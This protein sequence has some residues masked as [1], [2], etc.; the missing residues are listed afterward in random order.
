[1]QSAT[2]KLKKIAVCTGA[3]LLAF[4]LLFETLG[5][6]YAYMLEPLTAILFG[7][8]GAYVAAEILWGIIYAASFI[9]PAILFLLMTKND[10]GGL[11]VKP[12][13]PIKHIVPIIFA[14]VAL[15]Y[16]CGFVNAM[17]LPT[18]IA[19]VEIPNPKNLLEFL[20]LV[21]T[22]A[23]VPAVSEE[24]LFRKTILKAL[25]PYGEGFAIITSA[26]LFGLMHQNIR[27][28]FYATMAGILLG[29]VYSRTRSYL[30]VFLIHLT[31]NFITTIESAAM[32]MLDEPYPIIISSVLISAMLISGIVSIIFLVSKETKKKDIYTDGSFEKTY[33]PSPNYVS[34]E[35]DANP[36]KVFFTSP[37]VLIFTIIS[38]VISIVTIII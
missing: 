14:C 30:C 33:L 8:T 20:L 23:V 38:I 21:F 34:E 35:L 27:Q 29:Y 16:A 22:T 17:I 2:E 13:F 28:I 7:E 10:K 18:D 15:I 24:F 6:A 26:V 25:L 1:M 37:T 36:V 4:L 31:N 9:L 11:N 5:T 3:A 19:A 32:G 12:Q